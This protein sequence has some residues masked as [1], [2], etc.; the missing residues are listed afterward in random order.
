MALC[1]GCAPSSPTQPSYVGRA[2]ILSLPLPND[3]IM[4]LSPTLSVPPEK[5]NPTIILR[6]HYLDNPALF[7]R[8]IT[9]NYKA[10]LL[11][12]EIFE[13]K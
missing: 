9:F 10:A 2:H 1:A 3:G 12:S 13:H 4:S 8:K 7:S 11:L 6:N 5:R